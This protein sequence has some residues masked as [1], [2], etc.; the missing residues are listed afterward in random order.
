MAESLSLRHVAACCSML[1]HVAACYLNTNEVYSTEDR[2][3]NRSFESKHRMFIMLL[4]IFGKANIYVS[5]WKYHL[6]SG[7]CSLLSIYLIVLIG[8]Y[9]GR[10]RGR[11]FSGSTCHPVL[12]PRM[13]MLDMIKETVKKMYN[14]THTVEWCENL[15]W[16]RS[17]DHY[18]SPVR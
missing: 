14:C 12:H 15:V 6:A 18:W 17:S 4:W 9:T 7:Q 3:H 5:C 1:Q 16:I 13:C 11:L 10:V 8:F 2:V